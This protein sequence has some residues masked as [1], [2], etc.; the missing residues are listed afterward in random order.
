MTSSDGVHMSQKTVSQRT[1]RKQ[2]NT[3]LET[4]VENINSQQPIGNDNIGHQILQKMG[5]KSGQPLGKQR[6]DN[7]QERESLTKPI[8]LKCNVG[9]R[10]L[11]FE[12]HY[13]TQNKTI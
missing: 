3:S 13:P 6:D 12:Q 7:S 8:E 9:T 10:G 2:M 1:S 11:G 4:L 5:W